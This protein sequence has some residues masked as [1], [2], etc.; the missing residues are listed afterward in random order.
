MN[1][2]LDRSPATTTK[3]ELR[4]DI[5][6][7]L[8]ASPAESASQASSAI[9]DRVLALPEVRRAQRILSCLSFGHEV[10]T[11]RLIERLRAEGKEIYVPRADPRD[12]QLHV[13][14]YPCDLR[15]LSFGLQQPPRGTAEIAREAIDS[16][17]DVVLVLG[18]GFD[19][20][21][22][23]LGYGSGYFDRFLVD[24]PFPAVGL[25]L[26]LQIFEHMPEE[27]HDIPM[28]AVL[29]EGRIIRSLDQ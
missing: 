10:D 15:T 5:R 29:T 28:T 22:Y 25:A 13:H 19:R 11:W 7:R 24:R 16:T 17:V 14:A 6:R 27:E 8:E 12:H 23:R 3:D 1:P 9:H 20:R 4:T 21:G 18:L 26:D 2:S